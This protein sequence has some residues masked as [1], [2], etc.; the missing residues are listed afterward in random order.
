MAAK[1]D[2]PIQ[3]GFSDDQRI[4]V[5]ELYDSAFSQ[6]Y[7]IAV[8]DK[9]KRLRIFQAVFVPECSFVA[10]H[11]DKVVGVAGFKTA[12]N[13]LL[14]GFS[15]QKLRQ[16]LGIFSAIRAL[17]VLFLLDRESTPGQL[18]MDGIA[19]SGSM[20]GKGI[21]SKLLNSI[22]TY[23]TDNGYD[24]VRLDVI[25]TNPKARKLYERT[26]FMAVKE[27][28]MSFLKYVFNFSSTLE[29]RYQT[30]DPD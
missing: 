23:A 7:S 28:S 20:R 5:A 13:A 15:Y 8:P 16:E 2:L 27:E 24:S 1:F 25:N 3:R 4:Q 17:I 9:E 11:N 18:L 10:L 21:G 12:E 22:I 29:M 26:G 14:G 30:K 6:K 19:V